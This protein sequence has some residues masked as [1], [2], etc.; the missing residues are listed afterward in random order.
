MNGSDL[1]KNT[2][3]PSLSRKI[4]FHERSEYSKSL[5]F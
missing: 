2:H 4:C 1:E 3:K 5:D